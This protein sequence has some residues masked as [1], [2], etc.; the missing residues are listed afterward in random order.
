MRGRQ[1][2]TARQSSASPWSQRSN[3]RSR[4]VF[5]GRSFSSAHGTHETL[6]P[7]ISVSVR[8]VRIPDAAPR[9]RSDRHPPRK[10]NNPRSAE[11]NRRCRACSSGPGRWR[12]HE[13][14]RRRHEDQTAGPDSE[15]RAGQRVSG[16]TSDSDTGFLTASG[17]L[18]Q[19][20]EKGMA[21]SAYG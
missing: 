2:L 21:Y 18:G 16:S 10:T 11:E 6:E 19:P 20:P 17:R 14:V 5:H 8:I 3:G 15:H 7:R 4:P 9:K 12:M 13:A 1:H